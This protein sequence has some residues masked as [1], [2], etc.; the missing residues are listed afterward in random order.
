MVVCPSFRMGEQVVYTI[1]MV[2]RFDPVADVT[3][4]G[5]RLELMYPRDAVAELLPKPASDD[6]LTR[7]LAARTAGCDGRSLDCRPWFR[8][9]PRR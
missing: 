4:D 5:L 1:A 3:R 2:A 7:T 9:R 6:G 8:L